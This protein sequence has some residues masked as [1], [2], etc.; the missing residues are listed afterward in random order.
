MN[1][2]N[3]VWIGLAAVGAA[4]VYRFWPQR[5]AVASKVESPAEPIRRYEAPPPP[6][7][8]PVDPAGAFLGAM[9]V[10]DATGRLLCARKVASD[11]AEAEAVELRAKMANR[12]GLPAPAPAAPKQP[13]AP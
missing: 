9:D 6:P 3:P 2:I 5:Q 4:L 13:P 8:Q 7:P 10:M 12:L 1:E 11:W